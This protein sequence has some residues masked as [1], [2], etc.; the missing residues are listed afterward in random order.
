MRTVLLTL[1]VTIGAFAQPA[2]I[3]ATWTRPEAP[4]RIIGNL[5]YVGTYDLTSFLITTPQGHILINTGL[6]DSTP[7]IR[8]S[9]QELG[10]DISAV[11]LLLTTQAH[12]DH[13]AAMA[14]IQKLTGAK[15]LATEGDTPALKDG[16]R[17]DFLMGPNSASWFTPVRVDG[18]IR[19]G[20]KIKFGGAELTA[21]I[22]PGHTPGS[23]S[24]TMMIRENGKPYRVLIANLPNI[25]PG[26]ILVGNA[27]Y[28]GIA[29]DFERTIAA[30]KAMD[31]D[32][33]LSSH[34][35][36]YSL[37]DKFKPGDPYNPDRFVDNAGF[38]AAVTRYEKAFRDQLA[39]EKAAK[40]K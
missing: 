35:Q 28:P 25:N 11:K 17:S 7:Q 10:F 13:V 20:Q 16:G 23:V 24:Y 19:D 32:V 6:A 9:I 31:C 21:H 15:M 5:Y 22:H 36:H 26:T 34:A 14:E 4:H 1:V 39:K 30:Q 27:K 40:T 38:H 12:F 37:H 2:T 8:K 33:F 3:P 18:K 29:E